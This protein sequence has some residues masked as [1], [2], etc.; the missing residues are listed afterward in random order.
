M[1][2]REYAGFWIRLAAALIDM[3]IMVI[4]LAVPLTFI[5]GTEYWT[6]D[7][8]YY[9][10]WDL[11]LNYVVPFVATIWFWLKFLGTPGKMALRLR[12][13]DAETGAALTIGQSIGRYFAYILAA[14]PLMLGFIWIGV[15]KRKQGWHDKLAGTVV[16]RD[17]RSEPVH[18]EQ[19]SE[20]P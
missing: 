3:L 8:L 18:F 6:G 19:A 5:Y 13:V 17:R 2:D 1:E 15:D 16:V 12:L 11:L 7:E 4:V 9:G 20:A 10:I 14:I